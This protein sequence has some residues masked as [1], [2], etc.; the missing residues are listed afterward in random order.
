MLS[1]RKVLVVII[2]QLLWLPIVRRSEILLVA[3]SAGIIVGMWLERYVFTISSLA[4]N[5]MPSMW[6]EFFPTLWDWATLAGTIGLFSTVFFLLL[7]FV[8]I[9]SMAEVREIIEKGE[10][11]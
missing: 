6:G 9:V 11:S 5:Y 2:P 8:P 10:P 4:H 3:I 7:R 1:G